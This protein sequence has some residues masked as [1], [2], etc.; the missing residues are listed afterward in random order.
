MLELLGGLLAIS[1]CVSL[2]LN[3]FTV[4]IRRHVKPWWRN[5]KDPEKDAFVREIHRHIVYL[6]SI[7][8]IELGA[9]LAH[10]AIVPWYLR[11]VVYFIFGAWLVYRRQEFWRKVV[12]REEHKCT[13]PPL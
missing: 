11:L 13:N 4:E 6:G 1:G 12:K 10:I 7:L 8:S 3:E 9:Y 2:V 5:D